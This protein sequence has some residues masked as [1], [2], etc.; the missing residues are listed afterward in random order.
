MK[1]NINV[2]EECRI[3]GMFR[4]VAFARSDVSEKRKIK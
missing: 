3:L 4:R 2:L 1:N